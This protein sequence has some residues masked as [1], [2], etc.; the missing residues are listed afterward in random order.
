MIKNLMIFARIISLI[1][2]VCFAKIVQTNDFKRLSDLLNQADQKTLVVFDVDETLT[3]A[4]DVA[5]HPNYVQFLRKKITG[6]PKEK[7]DYFWSILFR[8]Q[9]FHLVD[10]CMPDRIQKLQK[11]G[12]R[13]V[14]L[15]AIP[16]GSFGV[17]SHFEELRSQRLKRVGIDF[18]VSWK[19]FNPCHFQWIKTG[20]YKGIIASD[21]CQKG[22]V[23]ERF[24]TCCCPNIKKIM[25][26]DDSKNNIDSVE[27]FAK[28]SGFESLCVH[29]T[30][31]KD[32]PAKLFDRQRTEFQLKVLEKEHKWIS[33]S[34]TDRRL[35]MMN[36]T[37]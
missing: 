4:D 21:S 35:Q 3:T 37:S 28:A 16:I 19:D 10:G 33:D 18:E 36:S 2:I 25:F 1:P 27:Q 24:V 8:D 26:V 20:F 15:T 22:E 34:E 23:L 29:Y 5:K 13:L 9:S 17:I 32:R 31:V 12:I 7:W 6:F 14:A 11:Q 30:A